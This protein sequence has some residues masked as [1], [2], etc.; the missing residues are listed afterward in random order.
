M[1]LISEQTDSHMLCCF[2]DGVST[3]SLELSEAEQLATVATF[4]RRRQYVQ[5]RKHDAMSNNVHAHFLQS[6]NGR[7][8]I[9][10]YNEGS[11]GICNGAVLEKTLQFFWPSLSAECA[12]A[13]S[14]QTDAPKVRYEW[15]HT[16]THTQTKPT[17]VTF[18]AHARQGLVK[19]LHKGLHLTSRTDII[20]ISLL[21]NGWWGMS[22]FRTNVPHN[23]VGHHNLNWWTHCSPK[24]T[25]TY[26]KH[27]ERKNSGVGA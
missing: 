3:L 11:A 17:T 21:R 12:T 16:H 18:A 20:N 14:G 26:I 13:F 10:V 25:L 5:A 7:P 15:T 27:P 9:E 23:K 8:H 22:A 1:L 4:T 19:V 6:K 24:H 2:A